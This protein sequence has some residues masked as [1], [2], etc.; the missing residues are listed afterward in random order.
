MKSIPLHICIIVATLLLSGCSYATTPPNT[1]V[2]PEPEKELFTSYKIP[3]ANRDMIR[4]YWKDAAGEPFKTIQQLKESLTSEGRELAFA[5]NGGIFDTNKNP[6]GLYIQDWD[7]QVP[8]N[9]DEGEGNFFLKPNG[10]FYTTK[11][12][13]GISNT[14][15]FRA[16]SFI[17]NAVQSGPLL[18]EGGE[19]NPPFGKHSKKIHIRSGGG[20]NKT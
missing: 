2:T 11:F 16:S 6:L 12:V 20:I 8:V 10:V 17:R 14:T 1:P 9:K 19:I 13:A 15:D 18:L 7:V 5:T 3:T 4:F